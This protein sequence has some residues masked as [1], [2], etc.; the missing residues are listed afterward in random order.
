MSNLAEL[1]IIRGA[2]FSIA[3]AISTAF[4]QLLTGPFFAWSF[5]K[6]QL[7]CR[8]ISILAHDSSSSPANLTLGKLLLSLAGPT[9]KPCCNR[10]Y[11]DLLTSGLRAD[12]VPVQWIFILDG[13]T[14]VSHCAV[15]VLADASETSQ[16][17]NLDSDSPSACS[18]NFKSIQRYSDRTRT[19]NC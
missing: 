5:A 4:E 15:C 19:H 6:G 8:H 17:W 1:S 7:G 9:G 2:V 18:V 13:S 11:D 14:A 3:S 10:C 16:C 12:G